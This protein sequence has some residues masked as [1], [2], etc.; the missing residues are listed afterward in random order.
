VG[1]NSLTG[2]TT[3]LGTA[4]TETTFSTFNLR[5]NSSGFGTI[6]GTTVNTS[7]NGYGQKILNFEII[8]S[9]NNTPIESQYS[10]TQAS[11]VVFPTT[12]S[13]IFNGVSSISATTSNQAC[14]NYSQTN[15]YIIN[16]TNDIPEVGDII[17]NSRNDIINGNNNWITI[18]LTPIQSINPNER[19]SIQ[20]N[21]LGVITNVV[22]CT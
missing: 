18:G 13:R 12:P 3:V 5:L 22:P 1:L 14:S 8:G 16:T 10:I 15:S 4:F 11:I 20:V 9:S 21:S 2:T 7:N 19:Y 17:S 6:S